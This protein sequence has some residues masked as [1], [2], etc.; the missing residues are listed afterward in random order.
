MAGSTHLPLP[1]Q[2]L[3]TTKTSEAAIMLTHLSELQSEWSNTNQGTLDQVPLSQ[4]NVLPDWTRTEL[5]LTDLT[6]RWLDE[7]S[8]VCLLEWTYIH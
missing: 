5:T 1:T 2:L 7:F 3:T 8:A 6:A 4:R